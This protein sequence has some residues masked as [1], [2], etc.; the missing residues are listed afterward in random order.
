MPASYVFKPGNAPLIIS[1]PHMGVEVP[2]DL[3]AKM[4]PV[5]RQLADTDWHLDML[6]DFANGMGASFLMARYSRFVVDLNRPPNDETLYPGQT[7]TGLFPQLTFRGEPIYLDST[8]P[9]EHERND[10]LVRYWHPYHDK[11][12]D[13]INRL[14]SEHGQVLVWE[15]H[16]IASVLPR[17]FE[18]K[19][20][21]LNIGTHAGKS[22]HAT[23]LEAI[24]TSLTSCDYTFALN[25]R[26]KG[27]YNTRYFGDPE[28]GVHTVQLEMCQSTYMNEDA[29]F[30]YRSDLA[31]RVKPVVQGMVQSALDAVLK[32]VR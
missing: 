1:I 12:A 25:G 15:A 7:K 27:G 24:E 32:L 13:E 2:P 14:R 11:L 8:E 3:F 30:D 22:A 5:G 16:S 17:L 29:P 21:D 20:P 31:D 26:F 6:Y 4:T 19:L 28:N 10:R 18:G 9:D 23:V